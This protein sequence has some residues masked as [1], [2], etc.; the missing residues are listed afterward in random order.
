MT[1]KKRVFSSEELD[2]ITATQKE[3]LELI[4][5]IFDD[6]DDSECINLLL[7]VVHAAKLKDFAAKNDLIDIEICALLTQH[8]A[9]TM[10]IYRDGDFQYTDTRKK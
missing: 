10:T 4:N 7:S 2:H 9:N 8:A 6:V 5:D 3:I 1:N